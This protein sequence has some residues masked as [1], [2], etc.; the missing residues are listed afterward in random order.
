MYINTITWIIWHGHAR[1]PRAGRDVHTT[2]VWETLK[3]RVSAGASPAPPSKFTRQRSC[4]FHFRTHSFFFYIFLDSLV[5]MVFF[6]V[7]VLVSSFFSLSSRSFVVSVGI[8]IVISDGASLHYLE[9]WRYRKCIYQSL[10]TISS[11]MT[12]WSSLSN[13]YN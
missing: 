3:A 9:L 4:T 1:G 11:L 6:F 8:K 12:S 10:H 2:V 7:C 13:C 5:C